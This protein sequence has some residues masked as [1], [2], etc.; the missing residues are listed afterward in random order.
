MKLYHG[1]NLEVL[2]TFESNSI[3]TC[4][5]DPPYGINFM[6]HKWDYD[7]PSIELWEEVLRVMKPGGHLLA[8]G[9]TRT[10]HRLVVNIEDAG[11]EIRD[12]IE[13][14]IYGSGF[15]KSRN[16]PKYDLEGEIAETFEG[17][18][19]GNKP[20][21]EPICV[22]MKPLDGTYA[23][24]AEK[25]G[26]AGINVDGASIPTNGEEIIINAFDTGAKPFGGAAGEPYTTRKETTKGRWPAN[27]IFDEQSAEELDRQSGKLKSGTFEDHHEVNSEWA[28]RGG[29][30]KTLS[31]QTYGDT[32]GASRFFY[33]AKPSKAEKNL[34]LA[35]FDEKLAGLK[36]ESGRGYSETDP[37]KEIRYKNH[38]PTVKSVAL[39][40][41]LC[42]WYGQPNGIILDPFMGSG[43]TGV[44]AILEMF[45]FVGIDRDK[46]YFDIAQAR[47]DYTIKQGVQLK[48]FD[49][50]S[51]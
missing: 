8:F 3:A 27:I 21:H 24:N 20:A 46:E 38:H 12:R 41:Y 26:V 49:E 45:D 9:G 35:A 15:P 39:M 48:L 28:H 5:T 13:S 1:D 36:N 44:G 33:C 51:R 4:I 32:G 47:I 23:E 34:G 25:W 2:Q 30:R 43:S 16:F 7:V 31:S 17:Y 40:Q 11:F 37:Y 10:Y 18:G 6:G 29:E 22:A 19:T 42:K 14:W 50:V